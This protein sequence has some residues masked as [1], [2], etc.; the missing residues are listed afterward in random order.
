MLFR[1]SQKG[2]TDEKKKE[3]KNLW[4]FVQTNPAKSLAVKVLLHRPLPYW[5]SKK[6]KDYYLSES[7][8][9]RDY[10]QTRWSGKYRSFF[11]HGFYDKEWKELYRKHSITDIITLKIGV[12][13]EPAD[14]IHLMAHEWKHYLQYRN[15]KPKKGTRKELQA[16]KYAKKVKVKYLLS[17]A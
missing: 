9:N 5:A 8:P 1:F 4:R 16:E 12:R 6:Q 15:G 2:L 17:V 13:T 3:I 7:Y 11:V 10:Y 14:I